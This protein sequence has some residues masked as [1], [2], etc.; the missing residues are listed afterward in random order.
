MQNLVM[1][2]KAYFMIKTTDIQIILPCVLLVW[3]S[4]SIA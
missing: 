2:D 4:G 3:T 1:K